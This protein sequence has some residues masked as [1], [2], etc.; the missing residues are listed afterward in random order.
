M[1]PPETWS[2]LR[3]PVVTSTS[4]YLGQITLDVQRT[5]PEEKWFDPHRPQ[6]VQMLNTFAS[7]NVG[8]GY[9]QGMNYLIFPLWKV[10]YQSDP[11][12]AVE[13]T[14]CAMQSLMHM[15]LRT[16]PTGM[17]STYLKTLG[18]V[19]RL[20]CVT[21]CPKM[22]V[23]FDSDYEEFMTAVISSVMPTL[24]A[25][26]LKLNHVMLLWD[27]LFEAGSKRQMFNRAV[28][29]LVCLLVH[30]KNLFIYLPVVTAMEIFSRL[31]RQTLDSYVVAKSI[32]VFA[33]HVRVRPETTTASA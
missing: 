10:F 19:L 11:G 18:G 13:D 26:V 28:D 24:F 15:L 2:D 29:T 30:H 7:V 16:Y 9:I 5:F 17:F 8:M 21:L 12:W 20:R 1:G 4:A 32:E 27:Q 22:H 23:L 3:T 6:L 25:N 14:L 33:P 31:V